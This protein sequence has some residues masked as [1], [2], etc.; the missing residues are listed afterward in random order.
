MRSQEW[1]LKKLRKTE[2]SGVEVEK[3]IYIIRI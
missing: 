1:K 2:E 3:G